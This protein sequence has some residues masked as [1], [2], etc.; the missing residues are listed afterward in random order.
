[1]VAHGID[2]WTAGGPHWSA[3]LLRLV[4]A[5]LL[6]LEAWALRTASAMTLRVM[7][8]ITAVGTPMLYTALLEVTGRSQS[9]LFPLAYVLAMAAAITL[10]ELFAVGLVS[11]S[12]VVA[13]AWLMLW[14]DGAPSN[15][16]LAWT[17]IGVVAVVLSAVLALAFRVTHKANERLIGELREA[18][19]NVKTLKGLLPVCAWCHRI[20]N[21]AGYWEQ[22]EAYVAAHSE[23]AFSHGMC[24]ECF[25]KHYGDH[26]SGSNL[27]P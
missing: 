15:A 3:L 26:P 12:L 10:F 25:T 2:L 7:T 13:G 6:F 19:G 22:L 5:G 27:K 24:P 9:P 17:H 11:A 1:M 21:D 4:W 18:L 14:L 23:A 16:I 20:R 8:V